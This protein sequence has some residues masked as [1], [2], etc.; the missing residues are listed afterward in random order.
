MPDRKPNSI[1]NRLAATKILVQCDF[2]STITEEDISYYILDSFAQGDWR[3]LLKEY[4]ENIITVDQFNT[5]SFAMVKADRE[6]LIN[7]VK[8]KFKLRAGFR[9]LVDYCSYR[10]FRF[11]IVSNGL[12]FYI[13]EILSEIGSAEIEVHAAQTQ[14]NNDALAVQYIGPDG[15][16][17]ENGLKE[18]YI[19]L[20]LKDGY[21]VI[22]IGDGESD[23]KPAQFA[24]II[25]ARD[26]LLHYCQKNTI[27]HESFDDLNDVV[28]KLEL[29]ISQ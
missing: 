4:R 25:F 17:T 15:R 14:F 8:T 1:D 12:D 28:K 27:P 9:Q 29:L 13:K 21:R 22:Y 3:K 23:I 11:V 10:N 19:R 2:D 26:Q 18:L 7:I 16:R 6:T 5:N 20:F 24:H